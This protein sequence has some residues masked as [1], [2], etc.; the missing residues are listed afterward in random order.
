[1]TILITGANGQLGHELRRLASGL[2]EYR[3]LFTDVADLDITDADAIEAF[4]QPHGVEL[5]INCAAYTQVDQ[6]E[7]DAERCHRVNALAPRLL[8]ESASRHGATLIH[9]STDYVFGGEAFAPLDED[10]PTAPQSIYGHTKL[11]GEQAIER[12]GCS[13][14]ILRTAWL[15]SCYGANFVKT[16][17]RL[18]GER[19]ELRVVSDQIGTPTYAR[20]LAE[21]IVHIIR[22]GQLNKS[23]IYHYTNEGVASWYDFAEAIASLSDQSTSVRPCRS[24]EYPTK[25]KRPL[26][27]LLDKRKVKETFGIEIVHWRHALGQCLD[28]LLLSTKID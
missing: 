10:A 16:M 8:A 14:I 2:P 28:E 13:Y 9:V 17:L 21:L 22:T 7:D 24:S 11:E 1:M 25:A 20:H 23:G 4:I 19:P 18:M 15:Y 5:I 6:A 3:W 26:Y 27:S 12:S